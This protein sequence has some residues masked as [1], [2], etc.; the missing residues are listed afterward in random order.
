MT[1]LALGLGHRLNGSGA[2]SLA[3]LRAG[4]DNTAGPPRAKVPGRCRDTKR[5]KGNSGSMS[6]VLRFQG[7]EDGPRSRMPTLG[8]RSK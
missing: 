3:G 8:R 7:T 6:A 2:W 5:H 4:D 1:T